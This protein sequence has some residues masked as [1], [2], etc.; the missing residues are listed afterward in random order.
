MTIRTCISLAVCTTLVL[1]LSACQKGQKAAEGPD[2]SK[3]YAMKLD[4]IDQY[5]ELNSEKADGKYVIIRLNIRNMTVKEL[6]L[7]SG[8][9][10]L[11]HLSEKPEEQYELSPRKMNAIGL[12]KLP[13][14]AEFKLIGKGDPLLPKMTLK[15]ALLFELPDE[16]SLSEFAI[17]FQS[18]KKEGG[19]KGGFMTGGGDAT[20]QTGLP[21]CIIKLPLAKAQYKMNDYR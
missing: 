10:A 16:A 5:S 21:R 14:M 6:G 17:C 20:V 7:G 13:G 15:R 4:G 18:S 8:N 3:V 1:S 9:F 19:P 2:L 11:R 12:S